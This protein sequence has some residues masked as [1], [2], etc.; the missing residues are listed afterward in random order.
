MLMPSRKGRRVRVGRRWPYVAPIQVCLGRWCR[1][2]K[3]PSQVIRVHEITLGSVWAPEAAS[4]REAGV[5]SV[6]V[7]LRMRIKCTVSMAH[8]EQRSAEDVQNNGGAGANS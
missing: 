7:P 3:G 5:S 6:V 2:R 4:G 1:A 8:G